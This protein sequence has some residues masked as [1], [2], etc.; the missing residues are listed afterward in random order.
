MAHDGSIDIC[1]REF[2]Y[3]GAQPVTTAMLNTFTSYA[4]ATE[5]LTIKG[6]P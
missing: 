6:C 1:A 3:D 2:K 5:Y 4:A